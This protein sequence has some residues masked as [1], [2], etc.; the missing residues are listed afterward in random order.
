MM[1]KRYGLLAAI[2]CAVLWCS[3]LA[4]QEEE[5]KPA[6]PAKAESVTAQPATTTPPAV[7]AEKFD[8]TKL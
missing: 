2:G 8:P 7:P 5:K 6:D 1:R 4:A 3:T